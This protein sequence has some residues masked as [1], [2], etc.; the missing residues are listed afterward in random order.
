MVCLPSF[1][2]V[3]FW[4]ECASTA[5]DLYNIQVQKG[6]TRS[7]YE[8]FYDDQPRYAHNLQIFGQAGIVLTDSKKSLKAKLK[9]KGIKK[10]FVGYAKDHSHDVYMMYNTETGKV[11]VTRNIR[12]LE[13]MI[14]DDFGIP[15]RI[16]ATISG[17]NGADIIMMLRRIL[18]MKVLTMKVLTGLMP[19]MMTMVIVEQV[20]VE[21]I[22]VIMTVPVVM[23]MMEMVQ[24]T[25]VMK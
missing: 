21:L 1:L 9:S 12:W 15:S 13:T 7:L 8:L 3:L 16:S 22:T 4:A 25:E 24:P 23:I 2:E 17:E 19:M 5:S 10:Y 14:G 11:S 18:M 20:I 6:E